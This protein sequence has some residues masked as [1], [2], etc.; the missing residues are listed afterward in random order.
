MGIYS[1][2]NIYGIMIYNFINEEENILF[3]RKFD[4]IMSN[5]EKRE[6]RL[7][8]NEINEILKS[9]V[10]FKIYTSVSSTYSMNDGDWMDWEPITLDY[11]NQYF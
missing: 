9:K 1:S 5:E 11:F 10:L 2:G 4:I 7:F 3:E 6:A 8:Y